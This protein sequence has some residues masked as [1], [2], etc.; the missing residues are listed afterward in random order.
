MNV[1]S[2]HTNH[3]FVSDFLQFDDI[4]NSSSL[5]LWQSSANEFYKDLDNTA[6]NREIYFPS[7][8]SSHFI[9]FNAAKYI[10]FAQCIIFGFPEI[11]NLFNFSSVS[12]V[13]SLI[14]KSLD[15]KNFAVIL[16]I[17]Y[18]LKNNLAIDFESFVH[19]QPNYF[20]DFI[21]NICQIRNYLFPIFL[22]ENCSENIIKFFRYLYHVLNS[23]CF[24]DE[25]AFFI[26]KTWVE[27]SN[28]NSCN[29]GSHVLSNFF[30]DDEIFTTRSR[31]FSPVSVCS[32]SETVDNFF[33][34]ENEKDYFLE[35][36]ERLRKKLKE[37]NDM[38]ANF[39]SFTAIISHQKKIEKVK[40]SLASAIKALKHLS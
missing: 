2:T 13:K 10:L 32:I 30:K 25:E 27:I 4:F 12:D 39:S 37:L 19:N 34:E 26:E 23:F 18:F 35:K 11:V 40:T 8:T 3:F 1:D 14:Q 17:R 29:F 9:H 22:P 7:N 20:S 36:I 5:F 21:K 24:S 33:F 6:I 38:S 16:K 15:F 28:S 31:V